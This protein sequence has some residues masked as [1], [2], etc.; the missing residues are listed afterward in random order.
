MQG[1]HSHGVSYYRCRYAKEYA[2]ANKVEHPTNVYVREDLIIDPIDAWLASAFTPANVHRTIDTLARAQA[3][4]VSPDHA[5]GFGIA[6]AACDEKLARHRAALEAGADPAVVKEWIEQTQAERRNIEADQ[7]AVAAAKPS[8]MSLSEIAQLVAE[9]GDV[10][11][12]IRAAD[13]DLKAEIYRRLDLKLDYDP[14]T[15]TVHAKINLAHTVDEWF[16]SGG[17]LE[18]PRPIKGTSTSS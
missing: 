17:G 4:D 16:V 18:P 14:E 6:L 13:P 15:E 11:R 7:R 1:Q 9:V 10:T 3:V 12:A 5:A 8:R 2:I